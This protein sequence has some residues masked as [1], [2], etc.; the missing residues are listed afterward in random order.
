MSTIARQVFVVS[1]GLV[2]MVLL[3]ILSCLI[4]IP[5]SS[6]ISRP[7]HVVLIRYI[8]D[9][10]WFY[11]TSVEGHKSCSVCQEAGAEEKW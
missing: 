2:V 9:R 8:L 1:S 3:Y 5:V 10:P 7:L 6:S 4:I 11:S